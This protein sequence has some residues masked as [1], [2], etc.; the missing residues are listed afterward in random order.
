MRIRFDTHPGVSEKDNKKIISFSPS[1]FSIFLSL[2]KYI[3]PHC[4]AV[5]KKTGHPV[6]DHF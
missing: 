5:T 1:V 6:A 2:F 3:A 4:F